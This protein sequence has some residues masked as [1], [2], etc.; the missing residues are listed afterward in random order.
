MLATGTSKVMLM[1]L[2]TFQ[3]TAFTDDYDE[4]KLLI[5]D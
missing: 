2:P 5:C 3:H 4:L 1:S